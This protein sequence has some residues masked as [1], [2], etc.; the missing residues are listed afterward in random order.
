MNAAPG[1]VRRVLA[2]AR[3]DPHRWTP[4]KCE[5]ATNGSA[6]TCHRPAVPWPRP[7]ILDDQRE[8]AAASARAGLPLLRWD[9]DESC[10]Q[11]TGARTS[12]QD[13]HLGSMTGVS[14]RESGA[15]METDVQG[16]QRNETVGAL[17]KAILRV[18]RLQGMSKIFT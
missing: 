12:R 18:E 17:S 11:A 16:P 8:V 1:P 2:T 3:E 6:R 13:V 14:E 7:S 10:I 9:V 15:L 5:L 4:E